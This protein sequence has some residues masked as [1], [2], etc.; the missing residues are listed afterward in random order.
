METR[1]L[2]FRWE[3]FNLANTTHLGFP[4]RD[5]SGGSGDSITSLGADARIMQFA[6]RLKF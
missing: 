2:Q 3:M 4:C 5:V 1:S 6:L